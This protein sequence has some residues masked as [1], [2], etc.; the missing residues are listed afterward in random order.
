MLINLKYSVNVKDPINDQDA[1][2]KLLKLLKL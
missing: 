2:T 1:A